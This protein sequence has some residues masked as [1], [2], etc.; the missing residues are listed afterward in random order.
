MGNKQC[1]FRIHKGTA[2]EQQNQECIKAVMGGGVGS[3]QAWENNPDRKKGTD[4][5]TGG[6]QID[7]ENRH[8]T[9]K[10]QISNWY[11]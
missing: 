4:K 1:H 5:R 10:H 7:E 11:S 3:G 9:T 6:R 8:Q 2:S